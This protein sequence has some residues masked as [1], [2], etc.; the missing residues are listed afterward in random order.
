MSTLFCQNPDCRLSGREELEGEGL[1]VHNEDT[2][3]K[4]ESKEYSGFRF[5]SLC[6]LNEDSANAII[7]KHFKTEL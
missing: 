2:G 5:C 1:R 4:I 7:E 6:C 3:M